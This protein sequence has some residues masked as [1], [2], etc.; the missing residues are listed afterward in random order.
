[1]RM[2][3]LRSGLGAL[4]VAGAATLASVLTSAPQAAA[5]TTPATFFGLHVHGTGHGA[6]PA[7]SVAGS[8]RLW[9]TGTTWAQVQPAKGVWDWSRLDA[10]VGESR[11]KGVRPLLVLGMTPTWASDSPEW[12]SPLGIPGST[13]PPRSGADWKRYVERTVARYYARGVREFQTWNEPNSGFW[14]GSHRQMAN[15]NSIAYDVVHKLARNARGRLTGKRAY[16]GAVLVSPGLSTRRAPQLTWLHKYYSLP[17]AR[18][19]DVIA[20]HLYPQPEGTPE[21]GMVQLTRAEKYLKLHRV[22]RKPLWVTEINYGG[23]LGNRPEPLVI[24]PALQPAYVARTLLLSRAAGVDRVYWYAWDNRQAVGVWMT[25]ADLRS[26]TAAGR[27]WV[28]TRAWMARGV[29]GCE[30]DRRGT[31]TCTVKAKRGYGKIMWNPERRVGVAV[32]ARST[33]DVMGKV[34]RARAGGRIAVG[35]VPVYFAS[36]RR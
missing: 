19:A 34:T 10:A 16:P 14:A 31:W 22:D 23:R 25:K 32:Q 11:R 29:E 17:A 13:R 33:T 4:V 5:A 27:A 2:R 3:T 28:Q 20:L 15:L 6:L 18:K 1:M 36:S 7:K 35:P 12:P 26:K 21:D 24:K 8:V 30:R 9:D